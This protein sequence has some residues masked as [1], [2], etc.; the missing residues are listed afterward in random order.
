MKKLADKTLH[1]LK[2]AG[3]SIK[4]LLD[5]NSRF[6]EFHAT[7]NNTRNDETAFRN[8]WKKRYLSS[9]IPFDDSLPAYRYG[10]LLAENGKRIASCTWEEVEQI[11]QTS[12]ELNY[13]EEHSWETKRDAVR[14]GWNHVM[15]S[16]T[17]ETTLHDR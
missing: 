4:D 6:G 15:N 17:G 14:F 5:H 8:H 1:T 10:A 12:R 2:K 13:Q 9:G 16:H 11:A 7:D 3:K